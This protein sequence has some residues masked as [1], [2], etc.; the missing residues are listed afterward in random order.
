MQVDFW[1]AAPLIH[2]KI[3][4]VGRSMALVATGIRV[5]M[6]SCILC[7]SMTHLCPPSGPS[8]ARDWGIV[9]SSPLALKDIV[10]IGLE[11]LHGW[12]DENNGS[13]WSFLWCV[14]FKGY[15]LIYCVELG[16]FW[17]SGGS[18]ICHTS[19]FSGFPSLFAGLYLTQAFILP[20]LTNYSFLLIFQSFL[21]IQIWPSITFFIDFT[22]FLLLRK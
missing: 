13:T 9:R 19:Q 4:L 2:I 18:L 21:Q 5:R 7:Q 1:L 16:R 14:S 6:A 17:L 22:G 11:D 12:Q 15:F 10:R 20:L 8:A 3:L